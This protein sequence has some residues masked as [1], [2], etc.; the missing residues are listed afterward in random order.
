MYELFKQWALGIVYDLDLNDQHNSIDLVDG[1]VDCLEIVTRPPLRRIGP[2]EP[3]EEPATTNDTVQETL[4]VRVEGQD[5]PVDEDMDDEDASSGPLGDRSLSHL[6]LL[7]IRGSDERRIRAAILSAIS[8]EVFNRPPD[9]E[10]GEVVRI[11]EMLG[12]GAGGEHRVIAATF[13][14]GDGS[15]ADNQMVGDERHL[16]E[17]ENQQDQDGD[18]GYGTLPQHRRRSPSRLAVTT[19]ELEEHAVIFSIRS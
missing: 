18:D 13:H 6:D 11:L 4:E 12:S 5:G 19:R 14:V 10:E 3:I 16:G 15:G 8:D 2:Y 7:S 17:N 9:D 1:L